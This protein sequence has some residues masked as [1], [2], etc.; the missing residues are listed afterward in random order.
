MLILKC[1][2]EGSQGGAGKRVGFSI[3]PRFH[4]FHHVKQA[5]QAAAEA[6]LSPVPRAAPVLLSQA[7][8]VCSVAFCFAIAATMTQKLTQLQPLPC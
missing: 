8:S 6:G 7:F 3:A 1:H 5:V 2:A 4:S